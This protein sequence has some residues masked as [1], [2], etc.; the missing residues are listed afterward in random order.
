VLIYTH[1]WLGIAGS[2]VFLVWFVSGVVMMYER[3]P[4]LT[5]EERLARLNRLD[6]SS[7]A[8][9]LADAAGAAGVAP[10]R[11]RVGML[12]D[13]PVYR[14]ESAAGWTTVFADTNQPL[15]GLSADEAVAVI[16]R[17]APESGS[18]A[19]VVARLVEPDQWL[20]DG[21]LSRFLPMWRVAL[22][23]DGGTDYY[24]SDRTGEAVMKTTWRGRA[25]GYAGAVL[26]WTY[27]TPF[28]MKRELWRYSIIYAA[29][30]GCVMCLSGLIVGVWRFSPRRH[31]RLKRV[32]AHSPYAGWMWWHHYAGLAFG[33]FTFTWALSGALSLT[34]WDWAPSTEP[35]DAQRQVVS[36]GPLRAGA[37]TPAAVQQ[38]VTRLQQALP[39]KELEILQAAG[40]PFALAYRA[41]DL[42]SARLSRNRD[43]GAI[44]SAQLAHDHRSVWLD[45]LDA[46]LF[47]RLDAAAAT[48]VA[49]RMYAGQ[50]ITERAWLPAYDAYY[51]DRTASRPLPV[52]RVSYADPEQTSL[53]LDPQTGSIAMRQTRLSRANRWL[54]NGLHSFDL[55]FLYYRRPMWDI[56]VLALSLGGLMLTVTTMVP[57]IRRLRRHVRQRMG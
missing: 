49:D 45:D 20:L 39:V 16:R 57:A 10:D 5:P 12:L 53:Y 47:E 28:R 19:H 18:R 13:R 35:T 22:D 42:A 46:P 36:G 48:A 38:A 6:P 41:G 8:F 11:A 31:Y 44:M 33:L 4:R 29:L 21:G 3:M 51:Y 27:F 2:L 9:S 52:L 24:V 17:F 14:L 7:I 56:V 55:P 54:Y 25:F 50:A 23:D 34:P 37:V 30:V 40:R 1:R 26:H 15:R 43:V 32:A